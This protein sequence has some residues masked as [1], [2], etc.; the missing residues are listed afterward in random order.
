VASFLAWLAAPV[1]VATELMV[2]FDRALGTGLF[3]PI[4]GGS[5]YLYENL[6]WMFGHP[7]VYILAIPALGI[8]LEVLA[9]F[10]RRRVYAYKVAVLGFL[11]IGA[12]SFGVWQHHLFVSGLTP[13]LRPFFLVVTEL[14]S[15]PTGVL[16]LSALGTIFRARIRLTTAMLFALAFIPNFLLGGI[17]GVFLADV[18]ADTQLHGSY[19][20][21]AHFHFILMGGTIFGLFAACYYWLP[22]MTGRQLDER[23]GKLQ[24]W[25][26]W[27]AFNGTFITLAIVGLM[28][29][30]RRVTS[31]EPAL[32]PVNDIATVFA[33]LLGLSILPFLLNALLTWRRGRTVEGNVWSSRSVEWLIPVPAGPSEGSGPDQVPQAL[34]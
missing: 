24:F 22:K 17:T 27:V 12:L 23:L 30:S 8:M 7:E 13:N 20:V 4:Q 15:V 1:L 9:V 3:V 19:F 29:M 21:Q 14:I 25:V 18:P 2:A 31:Y 26:M 11:A 10:T 6:F 32:Q 5:A 28:G 16:I 33:Y 34:E